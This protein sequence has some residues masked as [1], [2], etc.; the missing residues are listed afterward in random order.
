MKRYKV[1]GFYTEEYEIEAE[2]E[3]E[4]VTLAKKNDKKV[5]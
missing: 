5:F 2:T 4:A 3:N 1:T